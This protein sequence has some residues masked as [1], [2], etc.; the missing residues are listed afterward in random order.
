MKGE[1][2]MVKRIAAI[3]LAGT[4]VCTLLTGCG[5]SSTSTTSSKKEEKGTITLSLWATKEDHEMLGEMIASFKEKYKNEGTFDIQ[6][7]EQ[8]ES[9][10]KEKLLGDVNNAGDVFTFADDQLS[11]LV[12]SGAIAPIENSK[13]VAAENVEGAVTAATVNDKMYAYPMTADNGYFMYYNKKYFSDSD[14][15]SLDKMLQVAGKAGKKVSMDWSS[16]WYLYSFFGKTGLK[17][18]LNDDGVTN[19]CEWNGKTGDVSGLDVAKAMKSIAN[20]KAFANLGDADLVKQIQKG[21]VIAGING[22]W[23]A[24]VIKKAW[25]NNYGAVKLPTYKCG[26]KDIQMASFAGYK[27]VGVNSYSKN[28]SWANKLASWITNEENQTIRFTKRSQGPSNKKAGESDEVKKEPA[29]QAVIAQS[30]S[31]SL[32]RV[33]GNFWDP[34]QKFGTEMMS[35]PSDGSLQKMLDTM[36]KNITKNTIQ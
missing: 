27:L 18:G 11:T 8:E 31:A 6:L 19:F 14:V 2:S 36:V 7:V 15:K 26:G 16:G 10:C 35:N 34:I 23:N 9:D 13:E 30:E 1:Y 22:T 29:I 21:E 12:A 20:N 28:K 24:D 4:M 3:L 17:F 25:G 33:G 32:Q 5:K